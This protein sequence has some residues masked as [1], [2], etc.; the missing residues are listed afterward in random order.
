MPERR[1]AAK[2]VRFRPEELARITERAQLCGR[3]SS[4]FIRETAL[5]AIPKARQ[6]A[7]TDAALRELARVGRHLDELTR[8]A[9]AGQYTTL[10][11]RL[12]ALVGEHWARVRS[13]VAVAHR[14][15]KAMIA[16]PAG[17]AE[18]GEGEP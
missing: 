3:T 17:V 10:T 9:Q 1:T 2:L 11:E 12:G 7:A 6:H 4:R 13:L 15:R 16:E 5:G 18:S 8:L 14:G